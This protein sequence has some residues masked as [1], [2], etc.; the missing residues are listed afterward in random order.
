MAIPSI[1]TYLS[2]QIES[3]LKII[4]SN[5]Y[6]IEEILKGVQ[7]RVSKSFIDFFTRPEAEIPIV[8][9][10]SQERIYSRG[11]IY[12]G[13][14]EGEESNNS[15]GNIEGTYYFK[16]GNLI[17]ET[18]VIEYDNLYPNKLSI[19]LENDIGEL[20]NI[21]NLTF[22]AED[23]MYTE[24]NKILF[25]LE[26]NTHLLGIDVVVNYVASKGPEEVKDEQGHKI[27]F[28]SLEH[29]SV[30]PISS[31]MDT[32]RCLDLIIKAIFIMMRNSPEELTGV[33]LQKL[34][35]GQMESIDT[36]NDKEALPELLYG[37]ETIVSY[38]VAYNLD[39]PI[40]DKITEFEVNLRSG[41]GAILNGGT[42]EEGDND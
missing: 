10:L 25:N 37:R 16:E 3:K 34:Q 4:L 13:L 19:S 30:L 14:R 26:G 22:S 39:S 23:Y 6:I 38:K 9:E 36:R 2:R 32:V 42:R 33:Q 12:I 7:P 31:N 21:E 15:L 5:R 11:C 8:Y 20:N 41:K 27:G 35:F 17:K 29:Y 18:S 24:G 1:D 28:T 40:W